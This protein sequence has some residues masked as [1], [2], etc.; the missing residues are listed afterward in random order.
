LC[1]NCHRAIHQTRPLMS[2]EQF[3]KQFLNATNAV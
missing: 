1:P 3:R 2:V